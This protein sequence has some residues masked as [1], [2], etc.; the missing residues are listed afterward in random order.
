MEAIA[1]EVGTGRVHGR[2]QRSEGVRGAAGPAGP[3]RTGSARPPGVPAS[4]SRSDGQPPQLLTGRRRQQQGV[5]AVVPPP[6]E[7][8]RRQPAAGWADR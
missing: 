3:A 2:C 4:G 8:L 6:A 5:L 7:Q 1:I